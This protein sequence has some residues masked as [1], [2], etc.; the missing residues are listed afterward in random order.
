MRY[1]DLPVLNNT[2]AL[3]STAERGSSVLII[4]GTHGNE[5]GQTLLDN[6]GKAGAEELARFVQQDL[7]L[8]RQS[9][10]DNLRKAGRSVQLVDLREFAGEPVQFVRHLRGMQPRPTCI[11]ANFCYSDMAMDPRVDA[12]FGKCIRAAFMP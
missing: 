11:V 3:A 9:V 1:D 12:E 5:L 10:F 8:L 6:G 7:S 4:T 2:G